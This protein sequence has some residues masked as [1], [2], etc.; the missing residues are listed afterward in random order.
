MPQRA[1]S[2]EALTA[3][4]SPEP[5][6][7]RSLAGTDLTS[8]PTHEAARDVYRKIAANIARVMQGQA[9]STRRLLA[10][11]ASGGHVLLEGF[12]GTGDT[13]LA[14]APARPT[15]ARV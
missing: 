14:Q 5:V 13:T 10:A 2:V 11:F 7:A 15:Y 4:A 8:A 12:P 3:P 6:V 1:E 9:G